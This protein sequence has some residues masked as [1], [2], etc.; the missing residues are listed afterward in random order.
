LK[1]TIA[2]VSVV[3]LVLV[4]C[5]TLP[6]ITLLSPRVSDITIQSD[7]HPPVL[8]PPGRM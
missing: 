6:S 8:P 2:V 1:K 4:T 3:V 7:P 5:I